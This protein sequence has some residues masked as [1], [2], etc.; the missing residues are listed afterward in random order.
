MTGHTGNILSLV[1]TPDGSTLVSAGA[2]K[3]MRFWDPASGRPLGGPT[4]FES[5]QVPRL[6]PRA[7]GTDIAVLVSRVSSSRENV[8]SSASFGARLV[9]A[10]PL[11]ERTAA[12]DERMRAVAAARE[13]LQS[14][15]RQ[16]GS[17]EHLQAM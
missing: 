10:T 1:F 12:R 16:D 9:S 5:T 6:A 2:D 17:L 15:A 13:I 14:A 8:G 11:R 4:Q 7:D 3:T